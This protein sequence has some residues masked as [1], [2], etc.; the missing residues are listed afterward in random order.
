MRKGTPKESTQLRGKAH[1]WLLSMW[2]D[3]QHHGWLNV[4][5]IRRA[6]FPPTNVVKR[7]VLSNLTGRE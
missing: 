2:K 4:A 1:S 7:E 6:T 5:K 3:A